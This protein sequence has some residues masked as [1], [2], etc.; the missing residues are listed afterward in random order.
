MN[1]LIKQSGMSVKSVDNGSRDGK[2][3]RI[4]WHA[5]NSSRVDPET[6]KAMRITEDPIDAE[7]DVAM[8]KRTKE[9]ISDNRAGSEYKTFPEQL[10]VRGNVDK[11]FASENENYCAAPLPWLGMRSSYPPIPLDAVDDDRALFT[12]DSAYFADPSGDGGLTAIS[13][14]EMEDPNALNSENKRL[15]RRNRARHRLRRVMR[16]RMLGVDTTG[17]TALLWA[18]Q[19]GHASMVETL[20]GLGAD[21]FLVNGS[22]KS[23][24]DLA[25]EGGFGDIVLR[26]QVVMQGGEDARADFARR[27]KGREGGTSLV[28]RLRGAGAL[29][30]PGKQAEM[31]LE[32]ADWGAEQILKNEDW[33][34]DK[35]AV[36]V[37][38]GEKVI[39]IEWKNKV[40][41]ELD[42]QKDE[43]WKKR[44][45]DEDET[46]EER[47]RRLKDREEE[48]RMHLLL[49]PLVSICFCGVSCC[50]S[51]F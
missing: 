38:K 43:E 1:Q 5:G 11:N 45:G 23:V 21:P 36:E 27:R 50:R 40:M 26:L 4:G 33:G 16:K 28:M 34:T 15:R 41:A 20:L 51:H 7:I 29:K 25:R 3:S 2:S 8:N 44:I 37:E 48:K 42:Q 46:P 39:A 24:L 31:T 22:G 35:K 13:A 17:N 30:Y 19:R 6:L 12:Q 32:E 47:A 49:H 10:S 9:E 14:D 18:G